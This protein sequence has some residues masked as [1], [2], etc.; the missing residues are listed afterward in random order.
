MFTNPMH[1]VNSQEFALAVRL[2]LVPGWRTFRKFG[3]NQNVVSGTQEIWPEGTPRVLPSAA[4]L[5]LLT[6]D[7]IQDDVVGITGTGAWVIQVEGL[8]ANGVEITDQVNLR[9]TLPA[10]TSKAFLRINRMFVVTAGTNET[11]VG[12]I[13]ASIGGDVQAVIEGDEG[14]T[15][16]THYTVPA[17]HTFIV[18]H[19]DMG[20]GRMGGSTDLKVRSDIK[21]NY[22]DSGWR[23]ISDIHLWD[24]GRASDDALREMLPALTELRQTVESTTSTQVD[25]SWGGYLVNNAHLPDGWL[26]DE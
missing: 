16:Q 9:G 15:H 20:V 17:G 13:S 25:C 23:A 3:M 2:G 22:P 24:G 18:I 8:D 1:N 4:N 5:A 19:Y 14:Q 26:L 7:S 11:N 6:S 21:L 10:F 12:Y